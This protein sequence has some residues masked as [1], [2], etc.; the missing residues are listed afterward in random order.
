MFAIALILAA[1][2]PALVKSPLD[3][4]WKTVCVPMGLDGRHGMIATVTFNDKAIAIGA[5]VYAHN[6]CD[7]ATFHIQARGTV[8]RTDPAEG[9]F[10]FDYTLQTFEMT[11]DAPD[12]VDTY[13]K[14][15]SGCGFGG[16][17]VLG[18]PRDVAGRT[19]API[20]FPMPRAR[21]YD[22]AWI[23]GDTMRIGVTAAAM[24]NATPDKRPALP[25]S[26]VFTRVTPGT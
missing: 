15:N 6:S 3:G 16:G 25:G 4:A 12:V 7:T 21:L 14:S 22:R 26:P 5:Q 19:C 13:N 10:A 11:L 23:T 2:L 24:G 18:Q 8:T 17:W 9:G 20:N 1:P